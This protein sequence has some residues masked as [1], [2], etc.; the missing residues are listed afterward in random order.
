MEM[1]GK[2]WNQYLQKEIDAAYIYDF[3]SANVQD[4]SQKDNYKNLA[5]IERKHVQ[6]WVRIIENNNSGITA[7]KPS[8]LALFNL[9]DLKEIVCKL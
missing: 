1:K 5:G 9:S 8:F 6:A 4:K 7:L 3:L 2:I